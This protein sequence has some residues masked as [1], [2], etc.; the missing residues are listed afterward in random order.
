MDVDTI[1]PDPSR[2]DMQATTTTCVHARTCRSLNLIDSSWKEN[3]VVINT[4]G[5][6]LSFSSN[7]GKVE[8]RASKKEVVKKG[9]VGGVDR[10]QHRGGRRGSPAQ[11]DK[12]LT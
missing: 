8:R 11:N 6:N 7:T 5:R 1:Y 10:V 9:G 3:F 2:R 4:H 12:L